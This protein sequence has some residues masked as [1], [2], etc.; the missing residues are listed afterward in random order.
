MRADRLLSI[1]LL[2]QT[3][4]KLTASALANELEVSRRTILRDVE[5][6]SIAGIPIYTEGGHGGGIALDEKYRTTLTGLNEAE[7]HS[8][9]IASNN[10]LL[11]EVGLGKAAESLLLKLFAA[12]P[13]RHQ[14]AVDHIRQRIYIDPV[15]WWHDAQPMPFWA[16]LQDA[17][18][19]DRCI[20]AVY[21][22]YNGKIDERVLEPYSLVSKSSTWYLVAKRQGELRT[23]RVARLRAVTVLNASFVRDPNFDL[24]TY[25]H[26]HLNEFAT[27]F[28][29]YE[30]TLRVHPDRINFVRWLTPGRNRIVDT[31]A[32]GWI[33]ARFQM[34]SAELAKMLVFGLGAQ[35][36]VIE[37]QGLTDAVIQASQA[38]LNHLSARA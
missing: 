33:T 7:V 21:E 19:R 36:E 38:M 26:D 29:E 11:N 22:N 8:L 23:Y 35:C 14:P 20:R 37:P 3:R 4:G 24:T 2:L 31:D 9:F 5:A 10:Q 13:A 28:M 18:Y 32:D 12:L 1:V 16:E 15:W 30:F 25:W 27:A 6:L 34:E 17:V